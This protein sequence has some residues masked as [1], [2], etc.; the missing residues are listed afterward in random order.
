LSALFF[1][2]K[3]LQRYPLFTACVEA[4]KEQQQKEGIKATIFYG[5]DSE[6]KIQKVFGWFGASNS[7]K[8]DDLMIYL[9][10]L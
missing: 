3:F 6:R 1:P 10:K 2:K 7:T 8:I 5:V 9:G 4:T